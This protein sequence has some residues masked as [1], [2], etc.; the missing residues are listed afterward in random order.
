M[1][2]EVSLKMGLRTVRQETAG[3]CSSILI[4]FILLNYVSGVHG[5]NPKFN[6]IRKEIVQNIRTRNQSRETFLSTPHLHKVVTEL[7]FQ[8]DLKAQ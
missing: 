6:F 4:L 5:Q 2:E 3:F 7:K 8:A 1:Q